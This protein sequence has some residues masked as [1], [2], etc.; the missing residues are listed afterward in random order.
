MVSFGHWLNSFPDVG[1]V[2]W[3]F[4]YSSTMD[5]IL[6]TLKN[7]YTVNQTKNCFFFVYFFFGSGIFLIIVFKKQGLKWNTSELWSARCYS[8]TDWKSYRWMLRTFF[9]SCFVLCQPHV[10]TI[11]LRFPNKAV[12]VINV[13]MFACFREECQLNSILIFVFSDI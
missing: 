13:Y 2:H 4:Y 11:V 12:H 1:T 10:L 9:S 8:S 6:G 3:W 5:E 7:F